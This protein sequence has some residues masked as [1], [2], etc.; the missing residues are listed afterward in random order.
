M[1]HINPY[2]TKQFGTINRAIILN[3]SGP[4]KLAL[5][6]VQAVL[7]IHDDPFRGALNQRWRSFFHGKAAIE[8]IFPT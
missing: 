8:E 2:D 3:A 5:K 7:Y 4:S 6:R 1:E